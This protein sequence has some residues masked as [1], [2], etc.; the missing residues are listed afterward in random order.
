MKKT[1]VICLLAIFILTGG[2]AYDHREAYNEQHEG[3]QIKPI[4]V[5]TIFPLADLVRQIG[6]EKVQVA[7]LLPAGASPHTF[8]PTPREMKAVSQASLLVS[9]GAGLDVWGQKLLTVTGAGAA[10]LVVTEGL[11]L[12]PLSAHNHQHHGEEHEEALAGDPHV[13]LDPVLVRDEIA[14]RLA[15]EM[16]RLWP[17]WADVFHGNL[18]ELQA[19]LSR[20]D[21]ELHSLTVSLGQP[22]FISFHSAW[23]Y[24]AHRYGWK[25]VA[26]VLE[27]PGQEPSARWLKE[28]ADLAVREGV[29]FI[30]IE[31]QFNSQPANLLAQEINGKVLMMDPLGGEGVEG[32]DSYAALMRSNM[33]VIKE[34]MEL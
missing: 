25:E 34:A 22:K 32:R 21:D 2:C 12:L 16:S 7:A 17:Q 1:A 5:A 8:E 23:G 15:G 10:E 26:S 18:T 14:P 30:I 28:L 13:W 3:E 20:L 33:A 31:P 4:V 11:E 6:G 9:V 19:E 24:L 27:Y 29:K